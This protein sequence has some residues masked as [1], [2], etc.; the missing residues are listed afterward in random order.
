MTVKAR[1]L[2]ALAMIVG[3]VF[4]LGVSGPGGATTAHL[5]VQ[6]FA[7]ANRRLGVVVEGSGAAQA[8]PCTLSLYATSDG[9]VKWARPRQF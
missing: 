7:F 9:G 4:A 8:G 5:W 6:A 1:G 3:S 2:L